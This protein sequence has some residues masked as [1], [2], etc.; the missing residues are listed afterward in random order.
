MSNREQLLPPVRVI[1]IVDGSRKQSQP[2]T[3]LDR[4]III[5]NVISAHEE[6]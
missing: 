6:A 3:D 4:E 1:I 2:L 5:H